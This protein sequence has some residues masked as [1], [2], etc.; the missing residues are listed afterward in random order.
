MKLVQIYLFKRITITYYRFLCNLSLLI[1][2]IRIHSPA[3]YPTK[4]NKI[5]AGFCS[6]QRGYEEENKVDGTGLPV[7]GTYVLTTCTQLRTPPGAVPAVPPGSR[8]GS[9]APCRPPPAGP[10]RSSPPPPAPGQ[11]PSGCPPP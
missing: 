10:R 7:D 6:I 11:R 2:R 9:L 3:S 1:L 4:L 8:G 5:K